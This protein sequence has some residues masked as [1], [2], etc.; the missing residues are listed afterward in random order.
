MR[1]FTQHAAPRGNPRLH[2]R[3]VPL[4]ATIRATRH[5]KPVRTI[6]GATLPA[7]SH[8]VAPVT[9][10]R[11]AALATIT[12]G[13]PGWLCQTCRDRNDKPTRTTRTGAP[14]MTAQKTGAI[15]Y[16][17]GDTVVLITPDALGYR[18]SHRF[19]SRATL[20]ITRVSKA[21]LTLDNG[22]RLRRYSGAWVD[23]S[24]LSRDITATTTLYVLTEPGSP[25][26]NLA[27]AA[28][29]RSNAE[30]RIVAV[31]A[32][33]PTSSDTVAALDELAQLMRDA[34]VAVRSHI[35]AE[36]AHKAARS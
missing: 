11:L 33:I 28:I 5:A 31:A 16:K 21:S 35:A 14:A 6:C 34:R 1:V 10:A 19:R 2:I 26:D 20:T 8:D 25:I 29:R 32:S 24:I 12:P 9:P 23:A 15:P 17:V 3:D 18:T 13:A 27:R 36:A 7:G 30:Q 4:G 22:L